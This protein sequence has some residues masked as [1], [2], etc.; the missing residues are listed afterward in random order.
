MGIPERFQAKHA[1]GLVLI[2]GRIPVRV[3]KPLPKKDMKRGHD[4][5]QRKRALKSTIALLGIMSFSTSLYA[6]G[7]SEEEI[8]AK[9]HALALSVCAPCHVTATDQ[10]WPPILRTPGPTFNDIANKP[11]TSVDSLRAFLTSSHANIG[12]LFKM[13]NP[14][15]V[16]YQITALTSYILSLRTKR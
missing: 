14:R 10:P 7:P 4:S 1:P 8:I 11:T 13:P 6:Q 16:D 3:K 12:T 15:L 5:I 2:R 9:G